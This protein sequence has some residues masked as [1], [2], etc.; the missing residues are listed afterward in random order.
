MDADKWT[1]ARGWKVALGKAAR[2][3]GVVFVILTAVLYLAWSEIAVMPASAPGLPLG[4]G[5]YEWFGPAF[6]VLLFAGAVVGWPVGYAVA[7]KLAE[8]SGLEARKLI[9]PVVGLVLAGELLACWLASLLR[10]GALLGL[11]VPLLGL[12]LWSAVGCAFTLMFR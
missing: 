1:P 5:T 10:G 7:R 9:L 6:A 3:T 4:S 11:I 8:D 12:L 2:R